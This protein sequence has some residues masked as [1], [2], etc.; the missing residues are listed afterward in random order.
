MN[1]F[2]KKPS[3]LEVELKERV[4]RLE[5]ETAQRR[6]AFELAVK[7]LNAHYQPQLTDLHKKIELYQSQVDQLEE[8]TIA[9]L[10]SQIRALQMQIDQLMACNS[11][12]AVWQNRVTQLLAQRDEPAAK[13]VTQF[14]VEDY[15]KD[16]REVFKPLGGPHPAYPPMTL[17]GAPAPAAEMPA[18]VKVRKTRKL[19]DFADDRLQTAPAAPA[20]ETPA[21]ADEVEARKKRVVV[22][23]EIK[24]AVTGLLKSGLNLKQCAIAKTCGVSETVVSRIKTEMMNGGSA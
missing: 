23:P 16:V 14:F 15:A 2:R 19:A 8:A 9:R 5:R 21:A 18:E 12:M 11:E 17:V 3:A 20:A 4:E 13:T 22:T 6:A 24:A 7:N 10:Q 1:F